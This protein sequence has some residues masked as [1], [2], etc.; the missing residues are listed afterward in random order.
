MARRA[1]NW[2]LRS[3]YTNNAGGVWSVNSNGSN[4]TPVAGGSYGVRPALMEKRVRVT[5]PGESRVSIIKGGYI[6]SSNSR[7]TGDEYIVPMP[8]SFGIT[9]YLYGA[10]W[11]HTITALRG[12]GRPLL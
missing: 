6:L 1:T 5:H 11:Q 3:P 9:G 8:G 10:I 12:R 4:N 2:W 7:E